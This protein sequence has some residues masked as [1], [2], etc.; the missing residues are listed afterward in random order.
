LI[1][2]NISSLQLP[3]PLATVPES[4]AKFAEELVTVI[5]LP[6]RSA[7]AYTKTKEQLFQLKEHD[8]PVHLF[9]ERLT[10]VNITVCGEGETQSFSLT[11]DV[12][13]VTEV[14]GVVMTEVTLEN[15]D[16]YLVA[17]ASMSESLFEAAIASGIEQSQLDEEVWSRWSGAPVVS[18]AVPLDHPLR[19]GRLY[20]YLP[21][22]MGANAPLP[23]LVNAP[24]SPKL[25]RRT[26]DE[27][28]AV[29]AFLLEGLAN[30]CARLLVAGATN[31]LEIYPESL[32]D[33]AC[34]DAKHVALLEQ[35]L[36]DH[37]KNLATL[38]FL[39]RLSEPHAGISL[40]EAYSWQ[41]TNQVFN[42]DLLSQSGLYSFIDPS[43]AEGRTDA[44]E[45]LSHA[46]TGQS[47]EPSQEMLGKFAETAALQLSS[48]AG[49]APW[50]T[51]YDELASTILDAT[52]CEGLR[53]IA[54]DQ[55]IVVL[56]TSGPQSSVFLAPVVADP[57]QVSPPISVRGRFTFLQT[58]ISPAT[59]RAR[60]PGISWLIKNQFVREY[61]TETILRLVA[62]SVNDNGL[63]DQER[64]EALIY[65]QQVWKSSRRDISDETAERLGFALPCSGGW[66]PARD[67][68][69]SPGWTLSTRDIDKKLDEFI[70]NAEGLVI[71][72][73]TL[74]TRR[75]RT[76]SELQVEDE[77]RESFG[78]F[79]RA[80]GAKSGLVPLRTAK[81]LLTL[82][83]SAVNH[84]S[85]YSLRHRLDLSAPVAEAWA[86]CAKEMRK[87]AAEYTGQLYECVDD[88]AYL[89]GQ[90]QWDEFNPNLRAQYADLIVYGL[91][92]WPTNVLWVTF[93]R[94]TNKNACQWPSPVLTF[95]CHESWFPQST[96]GNRREIMFRCLADSWLL[97]E[98]ET[99]SFLPTVPPKF[100]HQLSDRVVTE[101]VRAG[102]RVWD[103][104]STAIPRLSFITEAMKEQNQSGTRSW[105]LQLRRAFE[106]A[107]IDRNRTS[108]RTQIGVGEAL[109]VEQGSRRLSVNPF[110][111]QGTIYVNDQMAGVATQ[112]LRQTSAPILAV[113]S[114]TT[115]EEI[116]RRFIAAGCTNLKFISQAAIAIKCH[117]KDAVELPT[118]PL[119]T[120][121]SW[122][123]LAILATLEFRGSEIVTRGTQAYSLLLQ[124]FENTNFAVASSI[125]TTVDGMPVMSESLAGSMVLSDQRFVIVQAEDDTD[126][127]L[128]QKASNALAELGRVPMQ[129]G[130]I[131]LMFLDLEAHCGPRTPTRADL[132]SVL[133]VDLESLDAFASDINANKALDRDLMTLLVAVDPM[134]V[135]GD[136]ELI[137]DFLHQNGTKL[138]AHLHELGYELSRIMELAVSAP[139]HEALNEL[140]IRLSAANTN[141]RSSG[142]SAI[143]NPAGHLLQLEAYVAANRSQLLTVL[144]DSFAGD[145]RPGIPIDKYV[146]AMAMTNL[147]VNPSWAS[148]FWEVTESHINER[149][150]HWLTETK[151]RFEREESLR[152]DVY[153]SRKRA[154]TTLKRLIPELNARIVSFSRGK[155]IMFSPYDESVI[156]EQM[157]SMGVL[158]FDPIGF[159]DIVG[160]LQRSGAWPEGVPRTHRL[161]DLNIT[162][163][164]VTQAKIQAKQ[165]AEVNQRRVAEVQY[166]DAT[167]S[168]EPG[169]L[170][171]LIDRILDDL[172]EALGAEASKLAV[173]EAMG[174]TL[175]RLGTNAPGSGGPSAGA[176]PDPQ[177]LQ[178]IGLIGESVAAHWLLQRYGLAPEVTWRS[179]NRNERL[180]GNLGDDGLGYDFEIKLASET[181]LIEVKA[182]TGTKLE[183]EMGE[184]EVRRASSLSGH[185]RYMVLFIESVLDPKLMALRELPNPFSSEGVSSYRHLGTS[186][187]LGFKLAE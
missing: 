103:E 175:S 156:F 79:A 52:A 93:T 106:Q 4:V 98:T 99:P 130:A 179:R 169:S 111:F 186:A 133:H 170:D 74:R 185:E 71:D 76:P 137:Q 146:T 91:G 158:D 59:E 77:D 94:Y 39:P 141:L 63:P 144:R 147:T 46:V 45:R 31:R 18:V 20:T 35:A 163:E 87:G 37:S 105:S 166:G 12:V 157:E 176:R 171:N 11:R 32:I 97:R 36:Q 89:P 178:A 128:R 145:H 118:R 16:T 75:L 155:S 90:N 72:A 62:E 85:S 9:L 177:K 162:N 88:L 148:D 55:G 27:G 24:F 150:S 134:L 154:R 41:T 110:E 187:R 34:W 70:S 73:A 125:S 139:L 152:F 56:A 29:N 149:V 153:D 61:R 96:P 123:P 19:A 121:G 84:P 104:A 23:A 165:T 51:F 173:Q 22:G 49:Q 86:S 124:K 140:G 92:W 44:L 112:L 180:G 138:R 115:A 172:P 83:G 131:R 127:R 161:E 116:A 54:S 107:W 114:A 100:G 120:L 126:W 25:D 10:S 33:L 13:V 119:S 50:A 168:L 7:E 5:K 129:A 68:A 26:I 8:L 21:M 60:R 67:V 48:S 160:W 142:L 30:I 184:S 1:L 102:L 28:T 108:L 95:L 3:S 136:C 183:F 38:E 53:L 101:L 164:D 64:M 78:A 80:L 6:L 122:L 57:D 17:A 159:A 181:L 81:E 135:D 132:A 182:T 151:G 58:D 47:M 167:Y 2:A 66:F 82:A 40:S 117:A 15:S 174:H 143:A 42:A 69:M 113:R 109:V 43:R 65:A 14:D